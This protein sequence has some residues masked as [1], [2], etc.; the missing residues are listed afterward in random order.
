MPK[1][2]QV[3]VGDTIETSGY[4]YLFP[5]GINVGVIEK[6]RVP[7]GSNFYDIDVKLSYD[8]SKLPY[9][10]IYTNKNIRQIDSLV[11]LTDE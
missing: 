5:E 1:H 3:S 2:V 4:S 10:Y 11:N 7:P 9:V 6:A 8:M